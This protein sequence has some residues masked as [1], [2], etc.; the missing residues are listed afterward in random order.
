MA[1]TASAIR[2]WTAEQFILAVLLGSLVLIAVAAGISISLAPAHISFSIANA[3][4]SAASNPEASKD[5]DVRDWWYNFTVVANNTSRRTAVRYGS[6]S[7]EIWY[8]STEWVPAEIDTPPGWQRPRSTTKAAIVLAEYGQF[9]VKS[10]KTRIDTD[11]NNVGVDWP[12]TRVVVKA[13]VWFKFGLATTRIYTV[14]V[15]C[16]PVN[17]FSRSDF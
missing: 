6:L 9:D 10:N 7:A 15:S 17:F 1:T 8:S 14:R 3:T 11:G 12:N 16:W 5:Q 2:R 13:N 4:I